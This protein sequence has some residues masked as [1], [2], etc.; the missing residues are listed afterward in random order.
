[1][2]PVDGCF[3]CPAY[4]CCMAGEVG[5]D[6]PARLGVFSVDAN[7]RKRKFQVQSFE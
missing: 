7:P 4:D 1:M 5:L 6:A 2:S 3:H